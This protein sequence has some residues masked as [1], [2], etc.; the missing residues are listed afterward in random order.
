MN[1][2]L[3]CFTFYCFTNGVDAILRIHAISKMAWMAFFF[4]LR[5]FYRMR[6]HSIEFHVFYRMRSYVICVEHMYI[7]VTISNK[8]KPTILM[9]V[10]KIII[11]K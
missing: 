8:F 10:K 11:R 1:K 5:K 9:N 2:I 6:Q 3:C 7:H 4:R